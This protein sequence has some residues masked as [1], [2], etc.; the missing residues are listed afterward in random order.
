MDPALLALPTPAEPSASAAPPPPTSS[1]APPPSPPPIA[2]LSNLPGLDLQDALAATDVDPETF[3]EILD[4]FRQHNTETA[5]SLWS[6]FDRSDWK[7]LGDIAHDIKGSGA[8]IGARAL[9]ESARKLEDAARG[10]AQAPP[11]KTLVRHV[12]ASL[13]EVLETLD[14]LTQPR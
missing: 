14:S 12:A 7:A 11:S 9:S 2:T 13:G 1:Q 3:L 5:Q 10:N 4:L 8:S 6:A